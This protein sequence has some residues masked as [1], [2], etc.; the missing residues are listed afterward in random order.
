MN[1][2]AKENRCGKCHSIVSDNHSE[3]DCLKEQLKKVLD[4]RNAWKEAWYRQ[5]EYLMYFL[6]KNNP[7]CSKY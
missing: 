3:V 2:M 1:T 7:T 4:D 6:E 5:R